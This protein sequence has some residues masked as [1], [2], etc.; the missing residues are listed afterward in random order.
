MPKELIG[1]VINPSE[2]S[3]KG[4]KRT[5]KRSSRRK[6]SSSKRDKRTTVRSRAKGR[7]IVI[8]ANP[9]RNSQALLELA[10]G[11][12]TG[13]AAGKL[14]DRYLFSKVHLPIPAGISVGDVATLT[15]GLFLLKKGGKGKEFATGVVAG[16]GAKIILNLIDTFL[17]HN[18]GIVSLH[19]EEELSELPYELGLEGVEEGASEIAEE[20]P[21]EELTLE[22]EP[23][24]QL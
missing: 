1:M 20:I 7:N 11:T 2:K 4:K 8:I 12:A 6:R 24:Y 3:E 22:P 9:A 10:A 13:L 21:Q 18:K 14:L 23:A 17:F 5:A 19:G 16:A 15:G